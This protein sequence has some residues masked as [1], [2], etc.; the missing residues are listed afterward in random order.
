MAQKSIRGEQWLTGVG[1][2][3]SLRVSPHAPA[4][5]LGLV[6]RGIYVLSCFV[7]KS[8]PRH[9]LDSARNTGS[10]HLLMTATVYGKNRATLLSIFSVII[11]AHRLHHLG[12]GLLE[13]LAS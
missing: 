12:R 7:P 2:P 13:L 10:T 4:V 3:R 9:E 5:A 11:P 6:D 1:T 8:T